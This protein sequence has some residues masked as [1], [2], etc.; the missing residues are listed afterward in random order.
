MTQWVPEGMPIRASPEGIFGNSTT[1]FPGSEPDAQ[2]IPHLSRL[3]NFIGCG[4]FTC[5]IAER[6]LKGAPLDFNQS[7]IPAY[8]ELLALAIVQRAAPPWDAL[9]LVHSTPPSI[10]HHSR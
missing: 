9:F 4:A 1:T 7:H 3:S 8:R 10:R 2:L 6:L 5:A